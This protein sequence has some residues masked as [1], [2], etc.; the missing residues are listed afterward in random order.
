M[1]NN[2]VQ[3]EGLNELRESFNQFDNLLRRHA[4]AFLRD[5]GN[6]GVLQSQKDILNVGAVDTNELIHGM[7]YEL[8]PLEVT[9]RPSDEADKYAWFIEHGTKPHRAPIEALRPWAERH[10]IPVGAVWHKIA[11][12]GT[13]PRYMFQT[14]FEKFEDTVDREAPRF[15]DN[16]LR[17]L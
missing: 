16:I 15:I 3:I 1:A 2:S 10:G 8:D 4:R 17:D 5:M 7:H 12:E 9:I 14:T 13:D 6:E 11:T